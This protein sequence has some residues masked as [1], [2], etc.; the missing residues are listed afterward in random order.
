MDYE[1]GGFDSIHLRILGDHET[2]FDQAWTEADD[3]L[4]FFDDAML[5]L[6][7]ITA[8]DVNESDTPTDGDGVLFLQF[9]LDVTMSQLDPPMFY[10][11]FIVLNGDLVAPPNG[12]VPEPGSLVLFLAG[13]ST[14]ALWARRR[15]AA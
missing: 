14:L 2:I 11:D 7:S 3:W 5:D 6:G 1:S 15:R 12:Q 9:L 13:L 8:L 4:S 10:T